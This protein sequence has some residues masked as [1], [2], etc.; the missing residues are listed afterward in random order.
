M[1][2]KKR[3]KRIWVDADFKTKLKILAAKED[4]A[5][6]EYTKRIARDDFPPI[7]KKEK[8]KFKDVF[9]I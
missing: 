2:H 4:T 5:L 6:L 1:I 9:K 7:Q 3:A 8:K